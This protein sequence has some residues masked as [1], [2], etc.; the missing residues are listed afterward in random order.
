VPIPALARVGYESLPRVKN[1][2]RPRRVGYLIP[3][4]E[5][6]SLGGG[7]SIGIL[8]GNSEV[9]LGEYNFLL[10]YITT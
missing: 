5:L 10:P 9:V 1:H 8:L 2:T 7:K 6:P 4:P 3:V